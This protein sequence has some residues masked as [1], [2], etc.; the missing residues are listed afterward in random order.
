VA[1]EQPPQPL[2]AA[3]DADAGDAGKKK[4]G[5][6]TKAELQQVD[7]QV[8]QQLQQQQQGADLAWGGDFDEEQQAM[9]AGL[10]VPSEGPGSW[11]EAAA[12]GAGEEDR[13]RFPYHRWEQQPAA[14]A[15]GL[16]VILH[17]ATACVLLQCSIL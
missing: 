12:T 13:R 8:D 10:L 1:D 6:K 2:A 16:G 7:Q 4:R 15:V 9:R 17:S 5:R 3:A 11:A 14:G